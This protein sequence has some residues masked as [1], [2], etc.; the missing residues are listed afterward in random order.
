MREDEMT[1]GTRK[2]KRK[3]GEKIG[4]VERRKK[5]EELSNKRVKEYMIR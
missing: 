2:V 1:R 5:V 4:S 3:E